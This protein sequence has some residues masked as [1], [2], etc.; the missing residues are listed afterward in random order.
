MKFVLHISSV[1][2]ILFYLKENKKT[3]FAFIFLISLESDHFQT[4]QNSR[5]I[6]ISNIDSVYE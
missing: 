5:S 6:S 3:E 2:N 4:I 1:S